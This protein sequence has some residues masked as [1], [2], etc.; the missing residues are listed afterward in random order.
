LGPVISSRINAR[1]RK[2]FQKLP[3]EV[4]KQAKRTYQQWKQH[5]YQPTLEFKQVHPTRPVYSVRIS[6]KW[7]AVGILENKVMVW[8]WIG[9]HEEYNNLLNLLRRNL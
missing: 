5:P 1:F 7:R 8:F 4:Q 6:L 3:K 2:A 9:S